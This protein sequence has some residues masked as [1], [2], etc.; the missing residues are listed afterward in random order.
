MHA[1]AFN[2]LRTAQRPCTR[3]ACRVVS[4]SRRPIARRRFQSSTLRC[5]TPQE[6]KGESAKDDTPREGAVEEKS[7]SV[8]DVGV[9]ALAKAPAETP[10]KAPAESSEETPV[11]PLAQPSSET[12]AND[13]PKAIEQVSEQEMEEVLQDEVALGGDDP[14]GD[15]FTPTPR[16][17]GRIGRYSA[18]RA[19]LG[20]ARQPEGLP[21]VAIPDWFLAKNVKLYDEPYPEGSLSVYAEDAPEIEQDAAASDENRRMSLIEKIDMPK[22]A[23]YSLDVDVFMEIYATL[24]TG[25]A[26]RPPTV[27]N[28]ILRPYTVLQCPKEGGSAYLD[29][30]VEIVST[31]L[32]ADLVQI[33][34]QDVAQI[35]GPYIDENL[36]WTDSKISLL[37]YEAQKAVGNLD[38]E[39]KDEE[40]QEDADEY[41]MI[42][43][44]RPL[45]SLY[46]MLSSKLKQDPKGKPKP[47]NMPFAVIAQPGMRGFGEPA[48]SSNV[49]NHLLS[50]MNGA[51]RGVQFQQNSSSENPWNE[52]KA[53]A[54]LDALIG[55]ADSKRE[56]SI[57]THETVETGEQNSQETAP[58]QEHARPLIIQLKDHRELSLTNEGPNILELLQSVINKR[59]QEGRNILLIG[60]TSVEDTGLEQ[61]HIKDFEY[62]GAHGLVKNIFVPPR[63]NEAQDTILDKDEK[64]R[65]RQI[66]LRHI[67]DM[68]RKI[69]EGSPN[70]P[71]DIKIGKTL[72]EDSKLSFAAGLTDTIW[73]YTRV[74]KVATIMLGMPHDQ[75]GLD[76]HLLVAALGMLQQSGKAK[77]KW[78]AAE[79]KKEDTQAENMM[80]D[81]KDIPKLK[82]AL[83]KEK[84]D[85]VI[86]PKCN[87]HETQLLGGVV[88]PAE[89]NTSFDDV[90]AP[91]E[92]IEAL[93][94]LTNLS[95]I[96]PENFTYG[97]LANNKI[98]GCLLYGP[99]GTGKT[100]LAKAVA[101]ESGATVLEVSGAEVNNMY[102]GESEK[103]VK[104]IFSLA[105]KLA[106]CVVFLDEADGML[107][108]RQSGT[109]SRNAHRETVNQFLREWDGMTDL[110]CFM[111]VATNRPYDL[112]EAVLRRVPRRLLV[113]LP[114]EKDREAILKI[115]L[116]DEQLDPSLSLAKLARDTPFYSGSDLK[117]LSVAA[118]MACIKDENAL[119]AAHGG[120]EPY[121]FPPKRNLTKA[122]F[123][124]AMDEISA[125]I[126]DDMSSLA[127]IRK[128]DE[129]YGDRKG[130]GK[131]KASLGFGGMGTDEVE[132][133]R[134]RVRKLDA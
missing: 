76:G 113:D 109:A 115:Q 59:W 97:V 9:E 21:P 129:K 124:K 44:P 80:K 128:F 63:R 56:S 23:K 60:T 130:R 1:I 10:V 94:T 100:M 55:A 70:F 18:A 45:G 35:V 8:A 64:D 34:A 112:D 122:H 61:S 29:A 106:P 28:E 91:K 26:L 22:D 15:G 6:G 20:R 25:L 120:S 47:R 114:V 14:N 54:I 83:T 11:N 84:L 17:K 104:A 88:I 30:I 40:A 77:I 48:M 108:A 49:G 102:L 2:A 75:D 16:G 78:G 69:T 53:K 101:R 41:E 98:P 123:E 79:L 89:I 116:K 133:S 71:T 96:R 86:R 134:G 32:G 131:K 66:N 118:A 105:K 117:N 27:K 132:G 67:E 125:S 24:R 99:P 73:P 4:G 126:S 51:P 68:L 110:S 13:S 93:K 43:N 107:A 46:S 50:M 81:T 74:H 121:V 36:A 111:M 95:L 12:P 57:P 58:E 72:D 127:A 119:A 33:D 5:Q 37:G 90:H 3:L 62:A 19:R 52:L 38:V 92:T 42:S 82:S 31:R 85:T 65:V 7:E 39:S 87:K 103:N